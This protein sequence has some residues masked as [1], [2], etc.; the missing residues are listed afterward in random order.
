MIQKEK[1]NRLAAMADRYIVC[2]HDEC[3]RHEHCLR[4]L[5]GRHSPSENYMLNC[6]SPIYRK[7]QEGVCDMHRP[8]DPVTMP[9]GMVH[10]Y[11]EMPGRLEVSV[12]GALISRYGRTR[13]YRYR[14][15]QLPI[16]PDVESTIRQVCQ[17]QGWTTP[18]KF[19]STVEDFLF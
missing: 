15:G 8:A 16:T 17:D 18:L 13:Y 14:N 5:V 4:W 7:A 1:E 11:D 10:F 3:T 12:K 2:F 9:L 19:D 6:I